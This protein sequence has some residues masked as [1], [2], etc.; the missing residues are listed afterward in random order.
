[1]IGYS[2]KFGRGPKP[3]KA[4]DN[5]TAKTGGSDVHHLPYSNYG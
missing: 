5:K 2:D 3:R 4:F 1:M